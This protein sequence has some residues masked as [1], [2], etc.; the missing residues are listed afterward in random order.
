MSHTELDT[1]LHLSSSYFDW[2]R[3]LQV[4]D[5]VLLQTFSFSPLK[6]SRTSFESV[7]IHSIAFGVFSL[8]NGLKA[9]AVDGVVLSSSGHPTGQ[10]I[11]PGPSVTPPFLSP[12][13]KEYWTPILSGKKGTVYQLP[14]DFGFLCELSSSSL[15]YHTYYWDDAAWKVQALNKAN[16]TRLGKPRIS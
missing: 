2:L 15:L 3:C 8:S 12:H 14:G 16:K 5:P 1:P 13:G 6:G 10:M 7:F 11:T 4:G 9:K